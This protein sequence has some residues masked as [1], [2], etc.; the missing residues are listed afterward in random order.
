MLL[1]ANLGDGIVGCELRS[2]KLSETRNSNTVSSL[3]NTTSS[4]LTS[5]EA[6]VVGVC[7]LSA[8]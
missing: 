4:R 3:A 1:S 8:R 6:M 2:N 7:I 5:K